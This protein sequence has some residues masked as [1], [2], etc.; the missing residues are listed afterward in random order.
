MLL[1]ALSGILPLLVLAGLV[2]GA[3]RWKSAWSDAIALF[4]ALQWLVLLM[5]FGMLA[6]RLWQ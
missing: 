2:T 4:A 3:S 1:A 5:V 6:L